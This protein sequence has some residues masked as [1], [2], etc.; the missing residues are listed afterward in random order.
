MP[1]VWIL[2]P[3]TQSHCKDGTDDYICKYTIPE[4]E[5]GELT[6]MVGKLSAD[7]SGNTMESFYTHSVR[8][9]ISNGDATPA[10]VEGG[11]TLKLSQRIDT[12]VDSE[13]IIDIW[14]TTDIIATPP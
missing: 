12:P 4:G 11:K 13:T 7:T 9:T 6:T 1:V 2:S 10:I 3:V 8:L 5:T 14:E